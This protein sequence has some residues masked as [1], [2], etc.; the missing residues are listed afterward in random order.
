ME[1]VT[2][3]G[4]RECNMDNFSGKGKARMIEKFDGDGELENI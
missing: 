2:G 1:E 4:G 3:R